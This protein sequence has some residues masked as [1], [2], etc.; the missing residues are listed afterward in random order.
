[1]VQ[2]TEEDSVYE[3]V[4][5]ARQSRD[6]KRQGIGE[7]LAQ[8]FAVE[9]EIEPEEVGD[10]QQGADYATDEYCENHIAEV[11]CRADEMQQPQLVWPEFGN[12]DPECLSLARA[13][14]GKR[15]E[16]DYV[17]S[18]F[19]QDFHGLEY[20]EFQGL[21]L[22]AQA[23]EKYGRDAVQGKNS[24]HIHYAGRVAVIA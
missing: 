3:V 11:G 1:M 10:E 5:R 4:H 7:H 13:E 17:G 24:A 12:R 21:V 9:F 19:D 2:E 6:H 15:E 22:L 8:E 16:Q 20:R 14:G 23:G 18:G